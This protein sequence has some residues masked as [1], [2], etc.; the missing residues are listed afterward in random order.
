MEADISDIH[1][2]RYDLYI[3]IL[4]ILNKA[5][6]FP[7]PIGALCYIFVEEFNIGILLFGRTIYIAVQMRSC[8]KLQSAVGVGDLLEG[9]P[10]S[11]Y[12]IGSK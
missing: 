9:N 12:L 10:C 2:I 3:E 11:Q 1:I 7:Y 4:R 6:R 5:S 8:S